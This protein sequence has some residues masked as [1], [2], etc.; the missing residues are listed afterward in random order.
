MMPFGPAPYLKMLT[1]PWTMVLDAGLKG[2][3]KW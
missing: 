3:L 1:V 2:S